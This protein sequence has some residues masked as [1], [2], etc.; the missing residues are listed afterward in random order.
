M[1]MPRQQF[2]TIG[3]ACM[4][5]LLSP[6]V[7]A[8]R[9]QYGLAAG[10]EYSDNALL[11]A[12]DTQDEWVRSALLGF[13]VEELTS[14]IELDVAGVVQ[15]R[16][17]KNH[18]FNDDVRG[19][20]SALGTWHIVP[21]RF[22]WEIEDYFTQLNVNAVDPDTPDNQSNV[23]AFST[24]P[25]ATLRLS[26]V[27]RSEFGLRISRFNFEEQ[28]VDSTRL[29]GSGRYFR[30]HDSRIESSANIVVE[31]ANFDD[32]DVNPDY[33]RNDLFLGAESDDR[34]NQW[35]VNL[36]ATYIDRDK[37]D[38]VS[39][40]LG[41]IDWRRY[42]RAS[43]FIDIN[44]I[45][46][47]TDTGANLLEAGQRQ[48]VIDS[49]SDQISGD[50]FY[51]KRLEGVYQLGGVNRT[52][53]LR[54]QYRDEDYETQALDR[55]V[56]GGRAGFILN[57]SLALAGEAFIDY[58]HNKFFDQDRTEKDF[59]SGVSASYR[60]NRK[61]TIRGE[62]TLRNR[63]SNNPEFDYRENN[64]YLYLYYGADPVSFRFTPL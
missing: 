14:T 33:L 13:E 48:R 34:L 16:N 64:V 32:E 21:Q 62:Y 36:G 61:F 4:F 42:F 60:L 41:R 54:L 44:A 17:F 55:R 10:L 31:Q 53:V 28:G 57:R 22:R 8:L 2:A 37:D 46:Q 38:S 19:D 30:K 15:Y 39:G 50:I 20:V 52:G 25:V 43:S 5:I 24:G 6:D 35:V 49:V 3:V 27:S 7:S 59:T 9:G 23:N 63:N 47:L 51:E 12:N 29:L 45:A 1:K 26:P 11:T 40:F 58:R 56:I 18:T